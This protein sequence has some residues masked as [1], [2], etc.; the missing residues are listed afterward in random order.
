MTNAIMNGMKNAMLMRFLKIIKK[1]VK[2]SRKVELKPM[3]IL[4]D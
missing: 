1:T 3:M 2:L 4:L